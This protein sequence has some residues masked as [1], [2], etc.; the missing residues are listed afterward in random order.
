MERAREI[1]AKLVAALDPHEIKVL[2]ESERH[3]G[4]AGYREGGGSHFYVRIRS[5]AFSGLSR[6][7]RHRAVY[8]ALGSRLMS[9]IHALRL[10]VDT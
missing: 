3:R 1:S 2:D 7:A 8:T 5:S 4:H 10:D 6:V 9:S